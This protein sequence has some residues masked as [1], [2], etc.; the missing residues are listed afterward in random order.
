[1]KNIIYVFLSI[2]LLSSCV[3]KK[4]C[5]SKFPPVITKSDSNSIIQTVIYRDTIIRDTI[6]GDSVF[7]EVEAECD[8]KGK[9]IN[10]P[11]SLVHTDLFIDV[12]FSVKNNKPFIDVIRKPI[13]RDYLFHKI[14]SEKLTSH[15][16]KNATVSTIVENKIPIWI[17]LLVAALVFT[18]I[19]TLLRK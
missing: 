5:D 2:V 18:N 13:Y 8:T 4:K 11:K 19:L 15:F 1:M 3:T 16:T 9:L 6:P 7:I 10:R 17:W 14:Y 12:F